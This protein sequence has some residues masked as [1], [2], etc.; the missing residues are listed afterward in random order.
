MGFSM[1]V[2][3][4]QAN[5]NRMRSMQLYRMQSTAQLAA[6][7][8]ETEARAGA[9]WTDR[10]AA[11]RTGLNGSAQRSGDVI[12]ITLRGS[13]RYMVYLELAHGK[14]W[15]ILWPTMQANAQRIMEGFARLGGI[16]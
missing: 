13:V 2:S 4:L 15:A 1:D 6:K 9:P 10:T 8:M 7:E 5:L 3:A 14:R 12:T 16:T 11:A